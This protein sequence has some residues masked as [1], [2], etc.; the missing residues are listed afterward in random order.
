[1]RKTTGFVLIGTLIFLIFGIP[2]F[3]Y[4]TLVRSAES[5]GVVP[6]RGIPVADQF[7]I[8]H[9]PTQWDYHAD[10]LAQL[11][12]KICRNNIEWFECARAF[13]KEAMQYDFT[14]YETMIE[15]MHERGIE[16]LGCFVYGWGWWPNSYEVPR[17]DWPYYFAF[18][19]A[20]CTHFADII[21]YYEMWNEPNIGFWPGTDEDFFE[22]VTN[23][24]EIVRANDPTA[25]ILCPSVAGPDTAFFDKMIASLGVDRFN[26][27]FDAVAYHAYSGRNGE[28]LQERMASMQRVM[29]K[30]HIEKDVWITEIGLST[31]LEQAMLDSG[32]KDDYW[33]V[34]AE[35]V[36][37]IYP[38]TIAAGINCTFW[39]CHLDW[40][41]VNDTHGEGRF[42]LMYCAVPS[43]Y[44]YANKPAGNAYRTLGQL[45]DGGT[46][47]ADGVN[48]NLPGHLGGSRGFGSGTDLV[49][50]YTFYT[51]RNTT[52]L[53][54]WTEGL[55]TET[56]IQIPSVG[57]DLLE[58]AVREYLYAENS[59]TTP[60]IG[61]QYSC[62]IGYS[63][64]LLEL[65]YT[66]AQ[67]ASGGSIQ[68][69]QLRITLRI[70]IS[71]TVWLGVIISLLGVAGIGL[72]LRKKHSHGEVPAK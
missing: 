38:Q 6:V 31:A 65:N 68:P 49:W 36:L 58:F 64:I 47:Y 1:M 15:N 34:Q 45:L 4:G 35:Q 19:E 39:Y 52:V 40:C 28:Y 71:Q 66:A 2:G 10:N 20:F 18:V 32:Y 46:Y 63:P 22:F 8:S 33:V 12:P 53:V 56:T 50:A 25:F 17:S 67:I 57:G 27:L 61:S 29:D 55:A 30:Y 13:G 59:S 42:G 26:Q 43:Q 72:I 23:I 51:P 41:D 70:P 44:L 21:T 60:L 5:S 7:C 14:Y 54:L 11:G 3:I 24:T 9:S 37:K 62:S 69:L 16:F 48:I